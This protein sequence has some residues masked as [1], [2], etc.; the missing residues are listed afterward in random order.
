M[1][2][3]DELYQRGRHKGW[4]I[5]RVIARIY[6]WLVCTWSAF[7][8]EHIVDDAPDHVSLDEPARPSLS[9]YDR[10]LFVVLL[11]VVPLFW[12]V[13]FMAVADWFSQQRGDLP[14]R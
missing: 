14:P 1:R 6:N 4:P 8:R 3:E 13:T 11:A 5:S 9:F 2:H 10:V 7:I 12:G